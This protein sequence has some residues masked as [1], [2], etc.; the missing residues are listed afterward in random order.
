[1]TTTIQTQVLPDAVS[2]C[3]IAGLGVRHSSRRRFDNRFHQ[4]DEK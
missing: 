3:P 4:E 1:M 2:D